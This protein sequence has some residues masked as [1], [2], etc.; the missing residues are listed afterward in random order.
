MRNHY[1]NYEKLGAHWRARRS[2]GHPLCRVAPTAERVAVVG[3]FNGWTRCAPMATRG[4]FGIWG[5]FFPSRQ[6]LSIRHELLAYRGYKI[7]RPIRIPLP[8][9]PPQTA[10]RVWDL[11]VMMAGRRVDGHARAKNAHDARSRP[12]KFIGL[13]M[14]VPETRSLDPTVR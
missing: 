12:T 13:W 14:R 2:E 5:C 8:P 10:S 1:R 6:G 9:R 3:Y 11:S 7:A 4:S